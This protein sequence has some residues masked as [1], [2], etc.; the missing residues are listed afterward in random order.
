VGR[1]EPLFA[2]PIAHRGLH[3]RA[4]GVIENTPSA[5]RA[6]VEAGYGIE[7]DVQG[8]ADGEAVVFHDDT[9]D[10]LTEATGAVAAYTLGELRKIP[11]RETADRFWTLDEMLEEVSG[12]SPLFVE[13]KSR[14]DDGS[15]LASHV[16]ARLAAYRGPAAAESFDPRMVET[17]R[18]EQPGVPRGVIG[19]AFAEDEDW[20]E[21]SSGQRFAMRH[22]LHWPSTKPDFLS[23]DVHDLPRTAVRL[24]RAIAGTPVSS[25]TVRTPADQARAGLYADQMVFEGFRA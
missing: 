4:R 5:V 13:I 2:L 6:A 9:L 22:L 11:F 8:T 18:K 20:A 21:L 15:P 1:L 12:R 7:V 14:F 23:W 24:A 10:R 25:W 16:G 17:L 19:C 3:D